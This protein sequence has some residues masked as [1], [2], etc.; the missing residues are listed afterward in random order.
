MRSYSQVKTIFEENGCRLLESE[1]INTKT[2]MRYIA[3]CGHE[4]E[5]T[6]DNFLAGKGRVCKACRYKAQS[7]SMKHT[8]EYVREYFKN[9]GCELL[10]KEYVDASHTK[11]RYIARCG[12]VNKITFNKF[13]CGVGR[14]CNRCSKSI[15]YEYDDVFAAFEKRGCTLLEDSYINCKVPMK[16]I[17]TC[18]HESVISFDEFQNAKAVTLKCKKCQ[19]IKHYSY[20]EVKQI[21]SDNGCELLSRDYAVTD[22]RLEYIAQCGHK[23]SIRFSKFLVGQGRKCNKCCKPSGANH[24]KFNPVLTDEDRKARGIQNGKIKAYR[25]EVFKR[26]NYTCQICHNN[27]GGNLEAHHLNSWNSNIDERYEANNMI[28]LCKDCHKAFHMEY[29]FGNNTREQFNEFKKVM[30]IPRA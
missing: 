22:D 6:L 27:K 7:E 2:K 16:Y 26:D 18:G 8:Y 21:F 25:A 29:G 12:H 10:E 14:V 4:H 13:V 23:T 15:R 17:A 5:I 20:D 11:M 1:Y 24:W 19:K 28:T 30:E 3:Q 9:E